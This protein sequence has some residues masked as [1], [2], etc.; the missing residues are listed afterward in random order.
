[1]SYSLFVF[2]SFIFMVTL[3]SV[4]LLLLI[5]DCLFEIFCVLFSIVHVLSVYTYLNLNFPYYANKQNTPYF[6]NNKKRPLTEI[7]C[8]RQYCFFAFLHQCL[9]CNSILRWSRFANITILVMYKLSPKLYIYAMLCPTTRLI[10]NDVFADVQFTAFTI[11]YYSICF[12]LTVLFVPT[13]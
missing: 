11:I 5:F 13:S 4:F 2:S 1:M 6:S 10:L 12:F 7:R 3:F 9:Q 8:Y